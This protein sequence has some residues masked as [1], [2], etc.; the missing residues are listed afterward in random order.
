[1]VP[2]EL[3]NGRAF[4]S[5]DGLKYIG[6]QHKNLDNITSMS[7]IDIENVIKG[8]R[9]TEVL[10]ITYNP[11]KKYMPIG[12]DWALEVVETKEQCKTMKRQLIMA[13]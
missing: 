2:I 9:H 13:F 4:M 1:M 6:G 7:L 8:L 11:P 3:W 10:A 5:K 12:V